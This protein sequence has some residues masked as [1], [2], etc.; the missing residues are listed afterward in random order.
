ME[1]SIHVLLTLLKVQA[2]FLQ[3]CLALDSANSC[4]KW[5]AI[6]GHSARNKNKAVCRENSVN[7]L[8][9]GYPASTAVSRASRDNTLGLV[10]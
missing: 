1:S 3:V 7:R 9:V 10:P 2:R 6:A 8:E 4:S 5:V